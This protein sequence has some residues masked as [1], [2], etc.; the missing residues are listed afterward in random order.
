MYN[1]RQPKHR[2]TI[3]CNKDKANIKIVPGTKKSYTVRLWCQ[4]R[5]KNVAEAASVNYNRPTAKEFAA[6]ASSNLLNSV[7][8]NEE[9]R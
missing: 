7:A 4:H 6:L 5:Q 8:R 2:Q 1:Y 3:H 9:D